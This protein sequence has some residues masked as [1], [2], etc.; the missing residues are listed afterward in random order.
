VNLDGG[1]EIVESATYNAMVE[2]Y[3]EISW[4]AHSDGREVVT[5]ESLPKQLSCI[6][7]R[8]DPAKEYIGYKT[9]LINGTVP[10]LFLSGMSEARGIKYCSYGHVPN[11]DGRKDRGI[12]FAVGENEGMLMELISLTDGTQAIPP[13]VFSI[14]G[15]RTWVS[16]PTVRVLK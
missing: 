12:S 9:I 10:C 11:Y 4:S 1:C 13:D 2:S 7:P 5:D 6:D 3:C 16:Q 8:I 14:E 15:V